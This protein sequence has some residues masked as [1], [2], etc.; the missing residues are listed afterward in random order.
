MRSTPASAQA[1]R[2]S[3]AQPL[4]IL[5]A[6][7]FLAVMTVVDHA[8]PLF[9]L[10]GL[11]A[12]MAGLVLLVAASIITY[13]RRHM[14][15]SDASRYFGNM[16]GL[17]TATTA[18]LT[19][20]HVLIFAAGWVASGIFLARLIG[21]V[22]GW[23]SARK[24][25]RLAANC[26]MTTDAALVL[27]L[28]LLSWRFGTA[29]IADIVGRVSQMPS[30]SAELAAALLAIA[31]LARCAIP[32]LSRWL[33]ASM[34]APTPVSALMHAGMVNAGGFLL[35]RF[36]PLLEAAPIVRLSLVG[37]GAVGALYGIGVM[38]VRPDVK[39]SLAG[40]TVSQMSF[41]ILTCGLGAYAAALWHIVAHGLFKAWLFLGTGMTIRA[42]Q[43]ERVRP[44]VL[45]ALGV[46]VLILG[47][48][49][50]AGIVDPKAP[51]FLPMAFALTTAILT[52][53]T[54]P[55]SGGRTAQRIGT[56]AMV[57][58]LI[59][60]H[61]LGLYAAESLYQRSAPPILPASAQLAL[62]LLF[63]LALLWQ[64]KPSAAARQLPRWLYVRLLN[65]GANHA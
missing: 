17:L 26:F 49:F 14:R 46:S 18:F 9:A 23:S 42:P 25:A 53:L 1:A 28:G 47:T 2:Q 7:F 60:V 43:V 8:V 19:T 63:S 10:D 40:S 4:L 50:V 59:A 35:L 32:P 41:M 52:F 56:G 24:S 13:S 22:Q 11:T 38:I 55:Q 33:L 51:A 39:R 16:V 44:P 58:M 61:M 62:A 3:P 21:H 57:A 65:A 12:A 27:G 30:F 54:L 36:A 31:A 34:T 29:S 15:A 37:M 45:A 64:F 20:N 6:L 48:G 5:A